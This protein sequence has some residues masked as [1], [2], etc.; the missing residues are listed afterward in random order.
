[1]SS[2]ATRHWRNNAGNG[3]WNDATKWS[4]VSAGDTNPANNG[5]PLVTEPVNIVNVDGTARTVTLNTTAPAFGGLGLLTINLTNG[6]AATNTLQINSANN[7]TAAGIFVGGYTGSAATNGRG[8]ITQSAGI[9]TVNPGSDLVLGHGAGSTGTYTLSGDLV[10]NQTEFIGYSGTGVFNQSG[11][12]NL[13]ND[14]SVGSLTLGYNAGSSGTYNLSGGNMSINEPEFI[15]YGGTG[16]FNQTG[17]SHFNQSDLYIGNLATG[18]GTYT[19]SAGGLSANNVI[20]GNAGTGTLTV[21]GTGTANIFGDLSISAGSSVNVSGGTLGLDTVSG[22]GS[23]DRINWTAGKIS[24]DGDRNIFG[25]ITASQLFHFRDLS[26]GKHGVVEG[27]ASINGGSLTSTFKIHNGGIFSSAH[28][29]IGTDEF[30]GGTVDVSGPGSAWLITGVGFLIVGG[31]DSDGGVL[32]IRNGGLVSGDNINIVTNAN[33]VVNLDGG[34]IRFYELN[35]FG[36]DGIFNFYSGTLQLIGDR[37]IGPNA[38]IQQIFGGAP[39]L[40]SGKELFIEGIATLD[41]VVTLDGGTFTAPTIVNGQNLRLQRGTLNITNQAVTIGAGGLFGSTLDLNDDMTINVNQ[42][43]TNQGLVTGDGQIGGT[44]TNAATGELR[45][46]PGKSLKFTGGSNQNFGRIILA[47]GMVEYTQNLFNNTGAFVSGNGTLKAFSVTN[48]GTM[49]FAGTANIFGNVTNSAGG[50]VI[51]GGGGATIFYND[52]TNNGEIRTSTNGFTVFFGSYS[53]S[54][55]FT[56]TGTVNFEG[57][58]SPGSSPG[59][60]SFAGDV[61]LG[62]AAALQIEIGG[63]TAGTQHDKLN[64][65]GDLALDGALEVSLI[66]GFIPSAGQSFNILDWGSLAGTFSSLSLPTLSGLAW[67]TSQLYTT[68][69]LSVAA[70]PG[71]DGDFN[72]DGAV[73]AADYVFWR[74]SGGTPAAYNTWR[75][76]FGSSSGSGASTLAE[77]SVPEPTAAFAMLLGLAFF[78]S[79]RRAVE[80]RLR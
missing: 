10:A 27:V 70:A 36:G 1:L 7:L 20:V 30:T 41:T 22:F 44:F 32:N 17:G 73:D 77:A 46:E 54:G 31:A 51:S 2:A 33:G 43:I 15:G 29:E 78:A 48:N 47:G 61:A 53:G 68:G 8:A 52:V 12:Q 72:N 24:L 75:N 42:G 18:V 16:V 9:V 25:D 21:Q 14:S 58:V 49:N 35:E 23:F 38:T 50:K 59:N 64:V 67:N 56:G 5:I 34:T 19:I 11:G 39:T 3:N 79:S 26:A 66:N 76:N 71:L 65:A 60:V 13:I 40:T 28:G 37:N 55:T 45:G 57:G 62:A 80:V 74:K 4:S 63:L 69:V 6:G